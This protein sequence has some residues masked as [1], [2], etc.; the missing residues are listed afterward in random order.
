[1]KIQSK[2]LVSIAAS[3]AV[4]A[5]VALVA[6]S[7]LRGAETELARSSTYDQ[8]IRKTLALNVLTASLSEG[9]GQTD[10]G[11][12]RSLLASLDEI[13]GQSASLA[14]RE[15]ALIGQLQKNVREIRPIFGQI[16]DQ[17]HGTAEG[18][19]KERRNLLA[20]QISIK[21]ALIS[22]DADRLIDISHSRIVS[23]QRKAGA[24]ILA[25]IIILGLT[26]AVI[27]FLAGGSIMRAQEAL[28]ESEE[29]SRVTLGSIGD[30]VIAT[31][32][33]GLV[34]YLNPVAEQLTGWKSAEAARQPVRDVFWVVDEKTREPARDVVEWV[35]REGRIV[36]LANHA[37]L[38]TRDG[39]EVPVEDSAAPI[40]NQAGETVGV[41]LV[42][43]DVT[44][45]RR[46]HEQI[47]SL[48]RFPDENPYPVIRISAGGELL[49]ANRSSAA[50]FESL[51]CK[52]GETL[53]A[54]PKKSS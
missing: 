7:I 33:S 40:R 50:L 42:F 25:L 12:V 11:Q 46:A 23:A 51:G 20:S 35:L 49:Y 38:L 47:E 24:T 54:A 29:R 27:Y 28:G 19:E 43:H 21:V 1:M 44:A 4:A 41:V 10:I 18:V 8:I 9:S 45:R 34:T 3:I 31:D 30:A 36:S 48:A 53:P 16:S 39:R 14:P 5:V 32:A 26:N 6:F 17:G 2:L 13:L 22:D 37:V 52:P 15:E